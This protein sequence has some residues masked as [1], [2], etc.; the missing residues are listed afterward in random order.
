MVGHKEPHFRPHGYVLGFSACNPSTPATSRSH[1]VRASVFKHHFRRK[2]VTGKQ[3]GKSFPFSLFLWSQRTR[4][5]K[6]RK[7]PFTV[8]LLGE[9]ASRHRIF[10]DRSRW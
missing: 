1:L 3:M 10:C 7:L 6:V 4:C 9:F 8:E 5:G 2:F